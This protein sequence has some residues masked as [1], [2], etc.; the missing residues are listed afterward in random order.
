MKFPN[1]PQ[2]KEWL[3]R[4]HPELAIQTE[5]EVDAARFH[6]F[7]KQLHTQGD[8]KHRDSLK[9]AEALDQVALFATLTYQ[10]PKKPSATAATTA[11]GGNPRPP[12]A[13]PVE[14]GS[15][16]MAPVRADLGRLCKWLQIIAALLFLLLMAQVAHGQ[17]IASG[18]ITVANAACTATSCVSM[19]IYGQSGTIA[20]QVTGTF[21]GTLQFEGTLDGTNYVA[22]NGLPVASATTTTSTTATGMWQ[23]SSAGLQK[24]QVRASALSSGTAT[25]YL[26]ASPSAMGRGG[27]GSSIQLT[28]D[29]TAGPGASPLSTT[30]A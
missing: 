8:H 23:V 12:V 9:E 7:R 17:S 30:I 24:F 11:T 6:A 2:L 1:T 10:E 26:R 5:F 20:V 4:D 29:V 25:I 22:V 14:S 27:G 3:Q 15:G 19:T 13:A 28:G 18:D 16:I 21:T